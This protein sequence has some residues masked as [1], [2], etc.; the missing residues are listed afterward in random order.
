MRWLVANDAVVVTTIRHPADT[1]L[2]YFHF[3]KWQDMSGD[4]D[5]A[6]MIKD[7]ERPGK[8]AMKFAKY[9]FAQ[10]YSVSL[11][12]ARLGAH[13]VRY[14]DMLADPV[15]QWVC[16]GSR[17][18]SYRRAASRRRPRRCF[19]SPNGSR[20]RG[21]SIPATSAPAPRGAG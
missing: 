19:A 10:S 17:R 14:E 2:S 11:S 16:I 5:A 6:A 9:S 20:A 4:P 8:N 18:A 15:R 13:V 21:M 3:A 1:L 12:W 7:G